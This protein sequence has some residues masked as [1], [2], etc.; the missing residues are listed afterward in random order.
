M[1][2]G[3]SW[4]LKSGLVSAR[5]VPLSSCLSSR[6]LSSRSLA[7]HDL[8]HLELLHLELLHLDP[9][10][11]ELPCFLALPQALFLER[12]EFT[13]FIDWLKR[14]LSDPYCSAC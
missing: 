14:V 3:C 6:S 9:L 7:S 2:Q 12:T 11:H 1:I 10:L 13:E 8:L 4:A 5:V